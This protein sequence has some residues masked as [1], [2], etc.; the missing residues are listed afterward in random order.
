MYRKLLL[1][2]AAIIIVYLGFVLKYASNETAFSKLGDWK[3][4]TLNFSTDD[5]DLVRQQKWFDYQAEA[6]K[7]IQFNPPNMN[8]FR[9]SVVPEIQCPHIVRIGRIADGGKWMCDPWKL[10]EPCLVYSL[11]VISNVSIF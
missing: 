7:Q 4:A 8:D 2:P 1:V 3:K 6:R 10:T 9:W 5:T 11:G